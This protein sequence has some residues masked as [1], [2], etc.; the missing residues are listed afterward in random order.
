MDHLT[1]T[2]QRIYR[3]TLDKV[4]GEG[5]DVRDV[6]PLIEGASEDLAAVAD[7]FCAGAG[8]GYR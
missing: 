2:Q 7:E 8:E 4:I 1:E 5:R 3:E 6:L